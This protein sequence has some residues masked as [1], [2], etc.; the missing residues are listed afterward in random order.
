[1]TQ[2]ESERSFRNILTSFF[3]IYMQEMILKTSENKVRKSSLNKHKNYFLPTLKNSA[4]ICDKNK[5]LSS[6]LE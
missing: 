5:R 6:K 2:S 1:M 4:S 3:Y